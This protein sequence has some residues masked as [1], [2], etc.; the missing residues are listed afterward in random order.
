[1]EFIGIE[2]EAEYM[3]IAKHRIEYELDKKQLEESK[4]KFW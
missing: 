4:R 1:M 2:R 3:E